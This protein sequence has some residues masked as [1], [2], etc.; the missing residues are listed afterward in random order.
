MKYII[1]IDE[2]GRGALAGP[3][4][5]GVAVV[6]ADFEWALLPGVRDSKQLSPTRREEIFRAARSL[7]RQGLI[8]CRVALVGAATIDRIGISKAVACGIERAM[9]RIGC[10]PD[11]ADVRLDGLLRAPAHYARQQTIIRGDETEPAISLASIMAKVTRDRHMVRLACRESRYS[12]EVHKGY[13]TLMHRSAL[14]EYGISDVH[15]RSFCK[16]LQK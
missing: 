9:A 11:D 1:G 4:A 10:S 15:R 2:A 13:G 16:S 6:P 5:V 3:V 12:F 8:E 7:E 14:R